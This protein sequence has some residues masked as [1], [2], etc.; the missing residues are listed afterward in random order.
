MRSPHVPPPSRSPFVMRP[1]FA[2]LVG[3]VSVVVCGLVIF[4]VFWKT[5]SVYRLPVDEQGRFATFGAMVLDYRMGSG[6]KDAEGR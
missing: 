5:P 6:R 1:A 4:F 3:T 2:L